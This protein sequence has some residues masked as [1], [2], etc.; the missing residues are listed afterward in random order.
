MSLS[1]LRVPARRLSSSTSVIGEF[2]DRS[3]DVRS[4]RVGQRLDIPYEL[5]VGEGYK[6]LWHSAF[7]EHCRLY[8]S[9]LFAQ[10]MGFE[11]S[12]LPFSMMMFMTGSMSHI[13]D[14]LKVLDLGFRN[15]V[16]ERPAYPGETFSKTFAIKQ[17]R[18]T[19]AGTG[20]VLTVRCDLCNS[21]THETVFSV[22]K[23]MLFP[24]SETTI[25]ASD[26]SRVYSDAELTHSK[27]FF[28][29]NF[30]PNV[31]LS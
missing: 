18:E 11:R 27:V 22:D 5:T 28:I 10:S 7:Y 26:F 17:I 9:D 12:L 29:T 16:Y 15:A 23:I 31:F 3:L 20:T 4:I 14:A 21:R 1:M 6:D 8:T 13:D 19:S 25:S 2:L 24:N 30:M